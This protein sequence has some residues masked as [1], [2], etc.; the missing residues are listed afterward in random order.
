VQK[1]II[2]TFPDAD[3]GINIIWIKKL[4]GDSEQTAKKT[5]EMFTDNRVSH[6][7]DKDQIVGKEIA[8]SIGWDGHTAWDIYLFYNSG[9]EWTEAPPRPIHWM[10]QLKDNWADKAH[11]RT[12]DDLVN[13]LFNTMTTLLN[14]A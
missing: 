11:F 2:K 12:G 8:K 3:I 4:P 13:A 5:A 7:Y 1:S 10:H 6:F 9:D 14:R